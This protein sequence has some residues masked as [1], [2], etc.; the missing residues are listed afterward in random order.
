MTYQI[1]TELEKQHA[2]V[3]RPAALAGGQQPANARQ[4]YLPNREQAGYPICNNNQ[5]DLYICGEQGFR[6]IAHDIER[7]EHSID[8]IVWGFDPAMELI[9]T[10]KPWPRGETY[11]DLLIRKAKAGVRVRLLAWYDYWGEQ[12]QANLVGHDLRLGLPLVSPSDSHNATSTTERERLKHCDAWWRNATEGNIPNLEV[13]FRTPTPAN[14]AS[15]RARTFKG[16]VIA[17]AE[18]MALDHP[19]D[20]QKPILIDY[21]HPNPAKAVGYVMGLNSVTDYWDTTQHEFNPALREADWASD[22][23]GK[24]ARQPFRDYAIRVQGEALY[25]LNHNFSQAWDRAPINSPKPLPAVKSH[26]V[27]SARTLAKLATLGAAV[28]QPKRCQIVR[29]QPDEGDASIW[30]AYQLAL[31]KAINYIYVE[32]QYFQLKEFVQGLKQSRQALLKFYKQAGVSIEKVP[33][34]HLFIVIPQPD[35]AGLLPRTYETLGGLGA[36][37]QVTEYH[38]QAQ[39]KELPTAPK[40]PGLLGA[41][42]FSAKLAAAS[43][44]NAI[45]Q[46]PGG[47]Q[48]LKA[49][50]QELEDLGIKVLVAML[51]SFDPFGK[52][53]NP[54]E[55]YRNIYIHSKLMIIDDTFTTLGSANINLRSMANDSEINLITEN[56]EFAK[57]ARQRVWRNIAGRDLEGG[58]A[59]FAEVMRTHKDWSNRMEQ[60]KSNKKIQLPFDNGSFLVPFED[61]RLPFVNL[62]FQ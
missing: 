25:S 38:K 33:P 13:R 51:Q 37:D 5:L 62:S 21:E 27:R 45:Y 54:A 24:T 10:G 39:F 28:T 30:A 8:I 35:D 60:N 43:T 47:W 49:A 17:S 57:T 11:G 61:A 7:A 9:R 41:L 50:R 55:R 16:K 26:K 12:K 4:W 52:S 40:Q 31:S 48:D 46:P 3:T 23:S 20:H 53:K 44:Y 29:T 32:N 15:L 1:K 2:P 18:A 58:E 34:L 6:A 42:G 19:T 56:P 59:S 36:Q 14:A 22:P